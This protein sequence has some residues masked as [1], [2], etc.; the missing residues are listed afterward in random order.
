MIYILTV[1]FLFFFGVE[2]VNEMQEAVK[3]K[4]FLS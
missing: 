4:D 2:F 1:I 3:H